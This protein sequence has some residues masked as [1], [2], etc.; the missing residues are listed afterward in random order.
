MARMNVSGGTGQTAMAT[1]PSFAIFS[2]HQTLHSNPEV[3]ASSSLHQAAFVPSP[4]HHPSRENTQSPKKWLSYTPHLQRRRLSGI[5]VWTVV[6]RVNMA[7]RRV[8]DFLLFH[9]F[10]FFVINSCCAFFFDVVHFYDVTR[11]FF[12]LVAWHRPCCS[13]TFAL[14]AAASVSSGIPLPFCSGSMAI[15]CFWILL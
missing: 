6:D 12:A 10:F 4:G 2:P 9:F 11:S 8:A 15:S 3:F 7:R 1:I 13:C 5:A 14:P